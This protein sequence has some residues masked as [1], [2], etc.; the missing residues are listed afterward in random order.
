MVGLRRHHFSLHVGLLCDKQIID[1]S[2]TLA[3]RS[4]H[5]IFL[6][7]TRRTNVASVVKTVLA[8]AFTSL[9]SAYS[10]LPEIFESL[11]GT[12]PATEAVHGKRYS[13][14]VSVVIVVNAIV[15]IVTA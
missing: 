2:S 8:A 4:P 11:W 13:H 6:Q 3:N 7:I 10:R 5:R 12:D 1:R 9:A 15:A 14:T